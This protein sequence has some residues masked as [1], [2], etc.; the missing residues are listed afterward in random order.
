M[1]VPK[2]LIP[3]KS[4]AGAAESSLKSQTNFAKN[5]KRRSRSIPSANVRGQVPDDVDAPRYI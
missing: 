3:V 4:T 1:V 5:W 2:T